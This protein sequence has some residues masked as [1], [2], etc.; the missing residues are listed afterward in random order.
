MSEPVPAGPSAGQVD[1]APRERVA[2][3]LGAAFVGVLLG[4][5]ATVVVWRLG[6]VAAVTGLA[7]SFGAAF[8][9]TTAAGTRPRK[10]MAALVLLILTGVVA[11]FFA[12]VVSD[13]VDAYDQLAL[14]ELGIGRFEFIRNNVLN[15]DVL[16]AYGRDLAM[17]ALFGVLGV[18]GIVR[19]LFTRD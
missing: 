7:I 10:G 13:L 3:G 11:A 4:I 6:Y 9:Y 5:G 16:G 15:G 19:R 18:L 8:L 12:V 14:A 17:F 2:L 1:D